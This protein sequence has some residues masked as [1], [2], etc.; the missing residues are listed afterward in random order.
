M[1]NLIVSEKKSFTLDKFNTQVKVV[2]ESEIKSILSVSSRSVLSSIEHV[3]NLLTCSGR[4]FL[5]IIYIDGEGVIKSA[6][7]SADFIEKQQVLMSVL[8]V[9]GC[10]KTSVK[11]D[12]FSGT[13]ILC[14]VTHNTQIYGIYKH[15]IANYAGESTAFVLNKK[16]LNLHE[17]IISK[18]DDFVIAEEQ[19]SNI[20][21]MQVLSV[22]ANVLNE[23]VVAAV[24][25]VVVDGKLLIETVYKDEDGVS[26]MFKEIEFKHELEAMSVMPNMITECFVEVRS[27]NVTPEEKGEKTNIVYAVDASIKAYV[28][29]ERA[30]EIATDMFSLENEIQNTYGYLEI[31]NFSSKRNLQ[32]VVMSSTDVSRIENFDDIVGVYA[33]VFEKQDIE[34]VGDKV[35]VTG[36][37]KAFAL[38]KS[39]EK[40]EKLEVLKDAKIEILKEKDE[41]FENL[42]SVVEIDSFKVKAGKDLESVFKLTLNIVFVKNINESYVKSYEI[43][44]SKSDDDY[45]IK[46][47]VAREGETVFDVA[48]VLSVRPE[49]IEEQNEVDGVFEQGEKIYV[50]SPILK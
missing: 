17:F 10:D 1:E 44:E 40:I 47:Y 23:E 32:E 22:S 35:Y 19:E 9:F 43:K 36:K 29:D 26:S 18:S 28:Y 15:E 41:R 21:N 4:V 46:V 27:I 3:N 13:E 42:D 12:T 6:E 8:D 7:G 49:I 20:K 24:D 39:A 34:D 16:E 14:S 38:Y 50:Y 37:I 48:K 2:A 31:Q 45:G 11:I 30:Y 33:P 25:K 5:N